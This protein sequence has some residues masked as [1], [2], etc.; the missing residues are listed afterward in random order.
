MK[1]NVIQE[2]AVRP[3]PPRK[4]SQ[5]HT[6]IHPLSPLTHRTQRFQPLPP[7]LGEPPYHYDLETAVPGIGKVAKDARKLVFHVV[8]DTG[9]IKHPEY[10][11]SVAKSMKS[12]LNKNENE[13]PNFFY[14]LGDVIYY[15]GELNKYYD[16][17]YEPYDHYQAP[18]I[19]IPGNHDG[20]PID[21]SQT[22]LD[23]WVAY[24]M[25]ATTSR[26]SNFP[27]CTASNTLFTERLFHTCLP[28]HYNSWH[29]HERSGTWIDRFCATAMAYQ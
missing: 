21:S 17:F 11:M 14:H 24:F 19:A 26:R 20:D 9:G 22:S 18:I 4:R 1:H 13:R 5:A 8:G 29:V 15:N 16:Q 12:D 27:R 6:G 28:L 23:G 25:T 3:R 10:Q 7:P 2:G